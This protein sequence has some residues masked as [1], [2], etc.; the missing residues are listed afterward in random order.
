MS[1]DMRTQVFEELIDVVEAARL[2]GVPRSW[3]Y[4]AADAGRLPGFKVG[5]YWRF[6]CSELTAWLE[7]QRNGG[8]RGRRDEPS[9]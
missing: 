4:S 3:I 5:K 7:E 6:R 2:L 1:D 8:N 9:P